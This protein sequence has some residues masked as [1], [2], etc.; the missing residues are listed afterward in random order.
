MAEKDWIAR[1]FAPL[2]SGQGAAGLRDDVAQLS[3]A[4]P[5]A[6]TTDAMVEGVHFLSR[7]PIDTVARTD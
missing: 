6:I 1:Y 7:D 3:I 2:A 5:V 4:G